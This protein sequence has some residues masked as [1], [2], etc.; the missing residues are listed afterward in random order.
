MEFSIVVPV[1]NEAG[2][3]RPLLAEVS[4]AMAGRH[5]WEVVYVDDGS[6]DGTRAELQAAMADYPALRV[7][8]HPSL[9]WPLARTR[10]GNTSLM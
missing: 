8:H 5:A 3:V 10:F 2:N 9:L 4:R 7:L 6:D 1:F